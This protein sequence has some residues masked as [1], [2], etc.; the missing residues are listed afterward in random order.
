MSIPGAELHAPMDFLT[1]SSSRALFKIL[2][3][4]AFSGGQLSI[5]HL[6]N[7]TQ[8]ADGAAPLM[9][10]DSV[11]SSM[12]INE[13]VNTESGKLVKILG[14]LSCRGQTIAHVETVSLSRNLR[15]S[16]NKTFQ[17]KHGQQFTI[18]LGTESD[19]AALLTKDWFAYSDDTLA[20]LVPGSQVELCLD[21]EYR[22]KRDSV[23]SSI[24]TTGCA[25]VRAPA[26]AAVHVAD[27]LFKCGTSVK[28]PV[29]EYLRRHEA[30]S[31]EILFDGDG[32]SLVPP[33]NDM[34]AHVIVPDT[35]WK[36]ARLSADGNPIHTNAYVAD[37]AGLP[38]PVTH[39]MWTGAS[40]RAL[41]EYYAANDKPER[42]RM[43]QTNFVGIV[44]PKD[45]LRTKL[46][47][48]GMK[49]GRMLV[50]GMTFKVNG[51]PV[52]E[53]TAEVEQPA[54][55]YVF[56]GQGSQEVG[57]GMDLYS[58]SAAARN[59][60]DRAERHMVDKYGL[61]LLAIVRTNPK[62]LT[63]HFG[64]L[65]GKRVQRNYMS[66]STG[67]GKVDNAFQ[68]FPDITS[69]SLSYTYRS[70]MGLLNATQF[71][72][73]ALVAYAM[74]AVADMRSKS[75]VQKG[76]SFAGHSLGEYA[77]LVSLSGLFT[78]EDVLDITFYRGMLMQLA[79]E[80]DSQ[81]RSQYGMVAV[82]PSLIGKTVSENLLALVIEAIRIHGQG[83]L[84]VAN[85]NVRGL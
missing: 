29:I 53:C 27:I 48:V 71:T 12:R 54:T 19:V 1:L 49:N 8:L 22:F 39:G 85:F 65:K 75:L 3:S 33:E 40:T 14:M 36:Y 56:T 68:L 32:Y 42:I 64:G 57:M 9:V 23:Y 72:Q 82:D 16:S 78:L 73:V 13:I 30:L 81:G 63:V 45:Q 62:E 80:R 84:E 31:D 44:Q 41:L 11:S 37:L 18:Q 17:R 6:Y 79:V 26:G 52:L 25:F 55:A 15:I 69:D 70:P 10:G 50:K 60:W 34:L 77:A 28:N 83:L 5:V 58:Q 2:A 76:A 66:L 7:K 46:F 51:D 43:Y 61:S 67:N 24:S 47:H 35:N 21:I 59:V 20:Y 4:T 38:G 74:A